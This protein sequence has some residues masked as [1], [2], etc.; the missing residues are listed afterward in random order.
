MISHFS[1][2][3]VVI[4]D[5]LEVVIV[6]AVGELLEVD[7]LLLREGQLIVYRRVNW[8]FS[9]KLFVNVGRIFVP[10]RLWLEGRLHTLGLQCIP[11]H[12]LEEGVIFQFHRIVITTSES[13]G[14]VR[15]E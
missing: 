9:Q 12:I 14:W 6:A 4:F 3:V 2:S 7:F 10:T 8:L 13:L 11:I 1:K 15:M 5:E